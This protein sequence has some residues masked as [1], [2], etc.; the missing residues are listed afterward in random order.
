MEQRT[1]QEQLSYGARDA[2]CSYREAFPCPFAS[3]PARTNPMSDDDEKP[4]TDEEVASDDKPPADD[5]PPSDDKNPA[6]TNP[7]LSA[8]SD[9][10]P[11]RTH[12]VRRWGLTVLVLILILPALIFGAWAWVTLNYS[13]SKGDRAGYVQKL[14][15]K[16]W[17]CKTWE[18]ELAMVNLPGTMPE[19][20][21]FSVRS[22]SVAHLLQKN[23]GKRVSIAYEEHR[24]VPTSCFAETPYYITNMRL[25]GD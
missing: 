4:V 10:M 18:G 22:D 7:Q 25:V 17:L 13:Y 23:I 9:Q 16:G 24:G 12:R 1:G 14:S 2:C 5:M 6:E 11:A 15:R 19:I 3:I 21:H 20:F 8:K